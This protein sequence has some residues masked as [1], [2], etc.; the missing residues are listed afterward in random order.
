MNF[1]CSRLPT[2][3][4][5][6]RLAL[7]AVHV[8]CLNIFQPI[9][10]ANIAANTEADIKANTDRNSG[11]LLII[12]GALRSDNSAVWQSLIQQAGGKDKRIA[13]IPAASGN[14]DRA[15]DFVL[16]TLKKYG[17]DAF[18]VPLSVKYGANNSQNKPSQIHQ[19]PDWIAK[20]KDAG[21]VYFTGGDQAKITSALMTEN[22]KPSP[23]LE[24][25]WSVYRGGGVIA[26]T[27]A[28]AAIMSSTMFKNA[29]SVLTTLKLGV[30]DGDDIAPGLGFIGDSI[31]IDQHL[32]I[33]GR[34]ARMLPVMLKKNYSLGIGID[35][36]TALRVSPQQEIEVIG[37]K[38][39]ILFDLSQ[40]KTHPSLLEFNVQNVE[41]SYLSHGDRF[42][43]LQKK[44]I[45]AP[46]KK[47]ITQPSTE[48][49]DQVP[50]ISP[51]ILGNT[52]IVEL[53]TSLV[54]G[55]QNSALGLAF[56]LESNVKPN[57]GF[58]FSLYKTP[59]TRAY[60]SSDSGA[61]ALTIMCLRLDV[62]PISMPHP[63]YQR[64]MPLE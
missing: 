38:G 15:A 5:S 26:G 58:E 47:F 35:E 7:T 49:H 30:T 19:H 62:H 11:S 51:N 64:L 43:L 14:P 34:F 20:I 45:P 31:F 1:I 39:A 41:I 56:S 48:D 42:L 16:Q 53:M 46:D 28:G 25:I 52:A 10:Q 8:L 36:N 23:M 55:S 18:V 44:I 27:S 2:K 32:I 33:R 61:E 54:E 9:A 37:Y 57:L 4:R 12:G 3:R 13:I 29:K 40:A 60:F 63:L 21:G 59:R 6:L 24:A 50:E 22:G 17:G